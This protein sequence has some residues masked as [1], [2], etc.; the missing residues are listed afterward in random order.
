[1]GSYALDIFRQRA[2]RR[3]TRQNFYEPFV[4][5]IPTLFFTPDLS[6]GYRVQPGVYQFFFNEQYPIRLVKTTMTA[7]GTRRV[8]Y[9]EVNADQCLM[10]YRD[11]YV[12]GLGVHDQAAF[13][14]LL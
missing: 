3:L 11:S 10:I 6:L 7:A 9:Q 14:W 2:Y 12:F 5:T 4:Y 1:V 13:A 8:G